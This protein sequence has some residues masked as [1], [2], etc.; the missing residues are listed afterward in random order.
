[1]LT[2]ANSDKKGYKPR[3]WHKNTIERNGHV[4]GGADASSVLPGDFIVPCDE[5]TQRLLSVTFESLDFFAAVDSAPGTPT[6]QTL[7][8]LT[9]GSEAPAIKTYSAM[10]RFS[11]EADAE[12]KKEVNVS[13]SN[14]VLFLTAHPC[15]P[16]QHTEM[17]KSPMSPSF[18]NPEAIYGS[19]ASGRLPC[20]QCLDSTNIDSLVGHPL[21]K[22]F[23]FT[24]IS[25]YQLLSTPSSIPLTSLLSPAQSPAAI[26][27]SLSSAHTTSSCIP[28]ALIIDCTDSTMNNIP[29]VPTIVSPLEKHT[30][31][32]FGSDLE[33]LA[34]A[35]CAERGWNALVSRRGRGCLA[36]AIR[37][38]GAVGWR[39]V[40]RVA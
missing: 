28:R 18:Q 9:N 23:T 1:M 12:A 26:N 2:V 5:P 40:L 35:L 38:A 30:K 24:K 10:M 4:I 17:L 3:I 39:V 37:E 16:S 20:I 33:M 27:R 34:R 32:N 8:P 15:D 36:C 13:L 25:L 22:A 7:T 14:D 6:K 19:E 21:H 11:I 29:Q 31:H